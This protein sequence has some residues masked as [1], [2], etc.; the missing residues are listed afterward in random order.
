MDGPQT[1]LLPDGRRLQKYLNH[2]L[3][4]QA[5]QDVLLPLVDK[6]VVYDFQE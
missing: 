5:K 2:P 4:D 3:H 6:V 1:T